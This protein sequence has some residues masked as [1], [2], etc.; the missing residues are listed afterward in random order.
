MGDSHVLLAEAGG[1]IEA[2]NLNDFSIEHIVSIDIETR[3][4]FADK[5]TIYDAKYMPVPAK[6]GRIVLATDNGLLLLSLDEPDDIKHH[7]QDQSIRG[8]EVVEPDEFLVYCREN[9]VYIYN[10]TKSEVVKQVKKQGLWESVK[11][12]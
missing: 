9:L 3:L 8:C 1:H 6:K 2:V 11:S 7:L 4:S 12:I 10:T 5:A